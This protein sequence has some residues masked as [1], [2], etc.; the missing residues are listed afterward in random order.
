MEITQKSLNF[1]Q[2]YYHEL[3]SIIDRLFNAKSKAGLLNT[4]NLNELKSWNFY[5]YNICIVYSDGH[6]NEQEFYISFEDLRNPEKAIE[7][8]KE[9]AEI[10]FELE[11]KAAAK[12]KADAE[13]EKLEFERREFERLRAKFE[14]K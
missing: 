10:K 6:C 11:C 8:Y 14:N 2:N 4:K 9:E 5:N 12:K 7:R 3:D 13:K 1:I